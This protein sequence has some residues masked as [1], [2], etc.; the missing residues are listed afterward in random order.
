MD[1]SLLTP[2]DPGA[3]TPPATPATP[4]AEPAAPTPPAP[5]VGLLNADGT[6]TE[7]WLDR[8]PDELKESRASLEKFQNFEQL[9]KSYTSLQSVMGKKADAVYLPTDKSTPEEIAAFR[10]AAGVPE[11]AEGYNLKPE[12]LPEGLQ[13]D[14][15]LG[16]GFAEIAHKHNIPAAA[17]QELASRYMASEQAKL[18]GYGQQVEAR[19]AASRQELVKEYGGAYQTNIQLATRMANTVGL[20]LNTAGLSD[21]NVVRALVNM[22]KLI[23]EDKIAAL[24]DSQV[25]GGVTSK[26][27]MTDPNN[28][29]HKR[30]LEGDPEAVNLVRDLMQRGL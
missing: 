14:D 21:P 12:Q 18:E 4:P 10:K 23:S 5:P 19:V 24:S 26:G 27:I 8:L 9:A 15:E 28:P 29:Y 16:R 11:T 2:T 6:F 7:G 30:Y 1:V 22:S 13:W 20:D 17:M 3:A 25:P